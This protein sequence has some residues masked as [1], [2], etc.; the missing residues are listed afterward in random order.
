MH[1]KASPEQW[2]H[3]ARCGLKQNMHVVPLGLEGGQSW[4]MHEGITQ[5]K[6]GKCKYLLGHYRFPE[7]YFGSLYILN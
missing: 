5:A 1:V 3:G 6:K 2:S 7:R 4:R